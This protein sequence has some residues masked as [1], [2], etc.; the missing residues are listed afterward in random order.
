MVTLNSYGSKFNR[1]TMEIYGNAADE[2]PIREYE[3]LLI[4]N[5]SIYIEIDTGKGYLYDEEN[6]VWK[7]V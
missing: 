1:N 6:H 3:G 4:P 2:K 5:G 7:E